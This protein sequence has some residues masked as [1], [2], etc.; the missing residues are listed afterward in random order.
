MCGTG[1]SNHGRSGTAAAHTDAPVKAIP[2]IPSVLNDARPVGLLAG[3]VNLSAS[4]FL[5]ES[6]EVVGEPLDL[7]LA[8]LRVPKGRLFLLR[9]NERRYQL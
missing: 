3:Y 2:L 8:G 4:M 7:A 1:L 6:R 9:T 5:R